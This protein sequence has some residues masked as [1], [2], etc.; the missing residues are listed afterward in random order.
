MCLRVK[1]SQSRKAVGELRSCLLLII[2]LLIVLSLS[3]SSPRLTLL[4]LH[5]KEEN[6]KVTEKRAEQ[7]QAAQ[8]GAR[9]E[10]KAESSSTFLCEIWHGKLKRHRRART[11]QGRQLQLRRISCSLATHIEELKPRAVHRYIALV[12]RCQRTEYAAIVNVMERA[13]EG[14]YKENHALQAGLHS[15]RCP[16]L[17]VLLFRWLLLAVRHGHICFPLYR[18]NADNSRLARLHGSETSVGVLPGRVL[19]FNGESVVH[20]QFS[21][22][23]AFDSEHAPYLST[24]NESTAWRCCSF[25]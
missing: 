9:L 25:S 1:A 20:P 8:N 21:Q 3:L 6:Y 10:A 7:G 16:L 19:R 18:R 11:D 5:V 15:S 2:C 14:L 17:L 4:S 22:M 12:I 23:T 13:H 24:P